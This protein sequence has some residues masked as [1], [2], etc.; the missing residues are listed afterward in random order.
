MKGICSSPAASRVASRRGGRLVRCRPVRG[1][2]GVD[3]FDHHPLAG[4][5]RAERSQLGGREGASVGVR[6]EP[7]LLE[8]RP[9]CRD[10]IVDRR[11]VAVFGEPGGGERV[12]GLGCLAEGEQGLVAAGVPSG[13]GDGQHLLDGEVGGPEPRRRFGERAVAA[14]VAAQHGQRDEHLRGE[15]HPGSVRGVPHC[16][17]PLAELLDRRGEQGLP[18]GRARRERRRGAVVG[19]HLRHLTGGPC[20]PTPARC[21]RS[22]H[23]GRPHRPA[24]ER[25]RRP[26]ARRGGRL[27]R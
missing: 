26:P 17:G 23:R 19:G 21:R 13:P 1:E 22:H 15:G 11:P 10:Q 16:G 20:R 25:P 12:P 9:A 6:E 27:P 7:G 24:T 2:V 18:V 4:R 14:L 3:R 8:H 5:H